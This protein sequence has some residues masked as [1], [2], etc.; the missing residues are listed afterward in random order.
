MK[1]SP[2]TPA[3]I[4]VILLRSIPASQFPGQSVDH[5]LCPNSV[6]RSNIAEQAHEDLGEARVELVPKGLL[7]SA[8]T[9]LVSFAAKAVFPLA[10][11][12]LADPAAPA[13][14]K[15]ATGECHPNA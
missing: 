14:R 13:G 7:A 3:A 10:R 12:H 15:V 5:F 11:G 2:A 4:V 8:K 9:V 1:H 6:S